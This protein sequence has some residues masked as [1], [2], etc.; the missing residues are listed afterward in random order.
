MPPVI[1][2]PYIKL[3]DFLF[4]VDLGPEDCVDIFTVDVQKLRETL[5]DGLP[6][7]DGVIAMSGPWTLITY[8][9]ALGKSR[10]LQIGFSVILS[11]R[12]V[13]ISTTI[14]GPSKPGILSMPERL[15]TLIEMWMFKRISRKLPKKHSKKDQQET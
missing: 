12:H 9:T 6:K 4:F 7:Q 13:R 5:W 10:R 2:A 8:D 15:K 1:D 14:R 11:K 3:I